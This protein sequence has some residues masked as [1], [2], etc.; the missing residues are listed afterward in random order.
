MIDWH[1]HILPGIDDGS[2]NVTESSELLKMLSDQGVKTVV[3]TP[4]FFANSDTIESF[5]EKRKNSYDTLFEQV[6]TDSPEILLGAEVKYYQGIS[7]MNELKKLCIDN[8]KLLLLEMSMSRWTE[9]TLREFEELALSRDITVVLA[10][11]E[12]YLKFQNDETW[13]RLY[14]NGILMQVNASFFTAFSTKRKALTYLE[15]GD[16]HFIGSDC[17]NLTSRAP[18]IGKAFKIIKNK[19][20]ESF[21]NQMNEYG[22]SVLKK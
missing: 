20:G 18:R 11:I 21:I 8:S 19:L 2:Q 3:A 12:R 13:N 5:L 22:Y 1:S 16:I 10:H 14:E 7:R 17:H 9:Y 15:N 4:H 6:L